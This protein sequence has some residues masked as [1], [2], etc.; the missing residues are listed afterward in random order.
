MW[1]VGL[2]VLCYVYGGCGRKVVRRVWRAC[3]SVLGFGVKL[4][5]HCDSVH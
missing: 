2:R 3:P 5:P 4:E 1:G